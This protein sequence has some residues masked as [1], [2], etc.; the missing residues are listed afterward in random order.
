[1]RSSRFPCFES[2]YFASSPLS[3]AFVV[4]FVLGR[5]VRY[6]TTIP[7]ILTSQIGLGQLYDCLRAE[8]A[9]GAEAG[10]SQSPDLDGHDLSWVV[11]LWD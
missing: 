3:M 6:V 1:M 11:A 5:K 4:P 2:P 9:L 10:A 7:T 8:S